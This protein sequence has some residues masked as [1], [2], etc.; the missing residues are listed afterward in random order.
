MIEIKTRAYAHGVS[1]DVDLFY[2]A[3]EPFSVTFAF[4]QPDEESRWIFDRSLLKDCLDKGTSG[5]GDIRFFRH[6]NDIR[7]LFGPSKDQM[8]DIKF[9]R[10]VIEHFVQA[11]YDEVPE[12]SDMLN[13]TDEEIHAWLNEVQ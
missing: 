3:E 5:Q 6:V 12:D 13:I 8:V 1:I 4:H 9:P 10:Q 7:M 2:V 11:V